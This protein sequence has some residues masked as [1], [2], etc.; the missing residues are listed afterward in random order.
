MKNT[1]NARMNTAAKLA[2][3]A[4]EAAN[5]AMALVREST[6]FTEWFAFDTAHSLLLTAAAA[7]R[8]ARTSTKDDASIADQAEALALAMT[9]LRNRLAR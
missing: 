6:T 7:V 5:A 8:K 1:E 4:I 9:D 3:N 2:A